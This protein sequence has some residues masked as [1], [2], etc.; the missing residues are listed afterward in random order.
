MIHS[1]LTRFSISTSSIV[2]FYANFRL[3][4]KRNGERA[5]DIYYLH[6]KNSFCFVFNA[7]FFKQMY[8]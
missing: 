7:N 1:N 8:T 6:Y 2:G 3:I 4:S 5:N